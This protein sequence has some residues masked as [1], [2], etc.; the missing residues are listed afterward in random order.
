[1]PATFDPLYGILK[2]QFKIRNQRPRKPPRSELCENRSFQNFISAIL[3]TPFRKTEIRCQIRNQQPQKPWSTK[4]HE[5]RWISKI[6]C[7]PF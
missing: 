1:M 5:N 6:L 3:D 7:P 2:I 4:F